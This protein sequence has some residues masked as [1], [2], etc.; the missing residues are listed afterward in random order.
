MAWGSTRLQSV[1]SST[2][3]SC[4]SWTSCSVSLLSGCDQRSGWSGRETMGS[5]MVLSLLTST[6]A[7]SGLSLAS[8]LLR[9]GR[10]SGTSQSRKLSNANARLVQGCSLGGVNDL[11]G[12]SD[13]RSSL[14]R[15][16]TKIP[17]LETLTTP[18]HRLLSTRI[19][20]ATF[21]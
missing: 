20:D 5:A 1:V 13:S 11:Q 9:H 21:E 16:S 14:A 3:L 10:R 18:F 4:L 19:G 15:N 2:A 12:L 8:G 17:L 6:P 7:T